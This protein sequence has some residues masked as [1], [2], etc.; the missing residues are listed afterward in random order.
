MA[1]VSF[2]SRIKRTLVGGKE[3]RDLKLVSQITTIIYLVP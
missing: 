3:D 1:F 2:I